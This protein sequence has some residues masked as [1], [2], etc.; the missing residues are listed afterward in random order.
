M[1]IFETKQF[2]KSSRRWQQCLLLYVSHH[3][4]QICID[5][6]SEHNYLILSDIIQCINYMFRLLLGHQ[7]VVVSLQ[8]NSIT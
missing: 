5:I 3:K 2:C 4:Y 6:Q 1:E 7:Q 8:S